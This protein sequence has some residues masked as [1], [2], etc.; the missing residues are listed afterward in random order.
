MMSSKFKISV[1]IM[2]L[3]SLKFNYK[4]CITKSNKCIR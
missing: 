4:N 1:E 2:D 3:R